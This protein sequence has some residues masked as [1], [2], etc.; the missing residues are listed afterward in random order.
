MQQLDQLLPLPPDQSWLAGALFRPGTGATH[1]DCSTLPHICTQTCH[2]VRFPTLCSCACVLQVELDRQSLPE[3]TLKVV[4]R[5]EDALVVVS[6]LTFD[7]LLD[8]AVLEFGICETILEVR[9]RYTCSFRRGTAPGGLLCGGAA[10][11][12]SRW[13]CGY[14]ALAGLE[15]SASSHS[16]TRGS[17]CVNTRPLV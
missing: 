8:S 10:P 3:L 12:Y 17:V 1:C 2:T 9:P 5:P 6:S 15:S 4:R 11:G 14:A 13:A 16:S 7:Y